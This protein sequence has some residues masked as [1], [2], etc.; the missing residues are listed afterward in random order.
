[1]SH[2]SLATLLKRKHK[3]NI[4]FNG[5]SDIGRLDGNLV[6]RIKRRTNILIKNMF[7]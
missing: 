2:E 4:K 5:L 3:K 6:F 7:I 1:M